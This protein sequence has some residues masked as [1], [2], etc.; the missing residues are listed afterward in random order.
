MRM[1]NR[2]FAAFNM[3]VS[4]LF[5]QLG[6]CATCDAFV[7]D[8]LRTA[9]ARTRHCHRY[10]W[11]GTSPAIQRRGLLTDTAQRLSE[12]SGTRTYLTSTSVHTDTN[13][14]SSVKTLSSEW[15]VPGLKKEVTRLIFRSHKKVGKAKERLRKA[16][17][18]VEE[19][20]TDDTASMD[21]L[22][23]CQNVEEFE[24]ETEKLLERLNG[25]NKLESALASCNKKT[26][27]L[28]EDVASLAL[29]LEVDDAP[30]SKP[31]RGPKKPKG[32]RTTSPRKPYRRYYSLD[33]TEIRVGKTAVE[34]D[35]VSTSPEH[36]RDWWMHAAGCPGSH[37]I[38]RTGDQMPNDEV[39]HDAAAL[40]ARHSKCN[41]SVI[42]VS[43]ARCRDIKKPPGAKPGLVQITGSVKTISVN[44]KTAEKRLERLDQTEL[45][46]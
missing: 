1:K 17:E 4:L 30:P 21:D 6:S 43:L 45:V 26:M 9:R 36:S 7:L 5:R 31:S 3:M 16:K 23:S 12:Y 25:L 2:A 13:E 34:N 19:L 37:I 38:I 46:N 41:G 44:M 27:V 15:N 32:P 18:R 40:A 11:I 14:Q 35:E 24:K 42:K 28:P 33:N 20:L 39:V 10:D 8:V 22:D 29:K